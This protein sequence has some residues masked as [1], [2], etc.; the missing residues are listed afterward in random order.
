VSERDAERAELERQEA[1]AGRVEQE[2]QRQHDEGGRDIDDEDGRVEAEAG[3]V[4]AEDKRTVAEQA[5]VEKR[6]FTARV[7]AIASVAGAFIMLAPSLVGLYILTQQVD[8]NRDT[9][10]YVCSTTSILDGLVAQVIVGIER[11][12]KDG[13]YDRLVS[14][15][16]LPARAIVD[17]EEQLAEYKA[18]EKVLADPEPCESLDE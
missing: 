10:R 14:N 11:N 4:E 12:L 15:G 8:Q 18:A 16:T 2:E 3:R 1:E 13:T 9:L 7:V 5:R 6:Y 17:A